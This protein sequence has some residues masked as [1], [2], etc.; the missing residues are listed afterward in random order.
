MAKIILASSNE[1]STGQTSE[2]SRKSLSLR[3]Y[4]ISA[5]I[6]VFVALIAYLPIFIRTEKFFGDAYCYLSLAKGLKGLQYSL[7]SYGHLKFLPVYPL[8]IL[9]LNTVSGGLLSY[10]V[11][12]KLI[13]MISLIV[14]SIL[15]F[16]LA[17]HC[18]R[19]Y[20]L[21]IFGGGHNCNISNIYLYKRN[22]NFGSA[23]YGSGDRLFQVC[24]P[25][26]IPLG[27]VYRRPGDID[28]L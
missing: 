25:R 12:A 21:S 3:S 26:K 24:L 13:T 9:L 7:I 4:L 27:L 8:A 14:T 28:A 6:L 18:T 22:Y 20:L 23:F 2:A 10:V 5:M 11:S 19:N 17:F 15:V 1:Q 16:N